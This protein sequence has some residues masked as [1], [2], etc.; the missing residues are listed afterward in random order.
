VSESSLSSYRISLGKITGELN[1][2]SSQLVASL[3]YDLQLD[4]KEK[5]WDSLRINFSD[6]D[7]GSFRAIRKETRDQKT[8]TE[9]CVDYGKDGEVKTICCYN[10]PVNRGYIF[11]HGF[12]YS[13]RGNDG[14][15]YSLPG[16]AEFKVLTK[17]D[18]PYAILS[19]EMDKQFLRFDYATLKSL[20]IAVITHPPSSDCT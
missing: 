2:T 19:K 7:I 5:G 10:Q 13:R 9:Q 3:F 16:S 14:V 20:V 17:E 18:D 6:V 8:T 4:Q 12:Q 11:G 1:V 15:I